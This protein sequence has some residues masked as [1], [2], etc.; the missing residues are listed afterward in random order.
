MTSARMRRSSPGHDRD[1]RAALLTVGGLAVT[2]AVAA[3]AIGTVHRAT[4]LVVTALALT[5]GYFALRLLERELGGRH[6]A[7]ARRR[8]V[9]PSV[10]L[11]ALA[12]VTALQALPLPAHW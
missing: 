7:R 6:S 9:L 5:T 4:V 11:V 10:G 3:V 12:L 8:L 1:E 2:V